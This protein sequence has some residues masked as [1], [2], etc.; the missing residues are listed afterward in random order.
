MKQ[1]DM[2]MNDGQIFRTEG[3]RIENGAL[4][5]RDDAKH[6][7]MDLGRSADGV[8]KSA[9]FSQLEKL[10]TDEDHKNLQ[11]RTYITEEE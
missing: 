7:C 4:Y 8:I 5:I 1:V 10:F 2:M 6:K 9:L 11:H 3:T